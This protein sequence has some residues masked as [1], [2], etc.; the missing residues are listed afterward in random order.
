MYFNLSGD[1]DIYELYVNVVTQIINVISQSIKLVIEL[2]TLSYL[3]FN[4]FFTLDVTVLK[5]IFVNRQVDGLFLLK[6]PLEC[7]LP[8]QTPYHLPHG[9]G[10]DSCLK[11]FW[12]YC[13]TS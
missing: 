3:F 9:L 13:T 4:L 12:T 8:E 7:C 1:V 5:G 10:L 11:S 2:V 6:S